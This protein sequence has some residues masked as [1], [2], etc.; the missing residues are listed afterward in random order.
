MR[1]TKVKLG[2]GKNKK[3]S[4]AER[5]KIRKEKLFKAA[6]TATNQKNLSFT[7]N[8]H[9]ENDNSTAVHESFEENGFFVTDYGKC[10]STMKVKF[11][12]LMLLQS[13]IFFIYSVSVTSCFSH[14]VLDLF[15][16]CLFRRN[17]RTVVRKKGKKK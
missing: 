15:C 5:R 17:P 12:L 14:T 6:G 4:G 7:V 2:H 8:T 11:L 3:K 16:S 10:F 1:N 9:I 13:L